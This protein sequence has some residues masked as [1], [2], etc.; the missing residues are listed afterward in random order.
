MP[1]FSPPCPTCQ[2][3][4]TLFVLGSHRKQ[5]YSE[6][7]STSPRRERRLSLIHWFTRAFSQALVLRLLR[8]SLADSL[9][10]SAVL[11]L[12]KSIE[13]TEASS[14]SRTCKPT[15]EA[16]PGLVR[17]EVKSIL[18]TKC[19]WRRMS[20]QSDTS[21]QP[22]FSGTESPF[23]TSTHQSQEAILSE[24]SIIPTDGLPKARLAFLE[25]LLSSSQ[26]SEAVEK[27]RQHVQREVGVWRP[28]WW[29]RSRVVTLKSASAVRNS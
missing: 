6:L 27:L 17:P 7:K 18:V 5:N 15:N 25:S 16:Q 8:R 28:A 24:G 20:S 23:E 10:F 19:P 13:V 26:T 2:R 14:P 4:T 9:A 1:C 12:T 11:N 21:H 3:P 22:S 29:Q